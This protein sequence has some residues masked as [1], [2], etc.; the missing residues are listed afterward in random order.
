MPSTSM[1]VNDGVGAALHALARAHRARLGALLAPHGLH[2]GQ[3]LLLMRVWSTP[4]LSQATLAEQLGVEPPTVTRMLQRMERGGLIERRR[5]PHDARVVS[6]HPTPRSRLLESS[7]RR[8]WATLDERLVAAL[9]DA[10]AE[11]L[12]RLAVVAAATLE[13]ADD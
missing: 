11:R 3:D 6:V 7:V 10:D 8:A 12:R 5:D 9:G 4:G 13:S 2:P 1:P